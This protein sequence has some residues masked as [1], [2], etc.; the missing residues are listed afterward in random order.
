MSLKI[1]VIVVDVTL[2]L[3]GNNTLVISGVTRH[4]DSNALLRI[5]EHFVR[6]KTSEILFSPLFLLSSTWADISFFN[7][8][9]AIFLI[10]LYI[11]YMLLFQTN[12]L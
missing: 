12:H 6:D 4:W 9:A 2:K 10:F 5:S 11:S 3:K 1:Y 8:G 7:V